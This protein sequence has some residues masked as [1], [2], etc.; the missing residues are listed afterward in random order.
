MVFLAFP[1]RILYT[2]GNVRNRAQRDGS[3][4]SAGNVGGE[5]MEAYAGRPENMEGR[6]PREI[7]T[8]DLLDRLGIEY[9]RVDHEA[10]K[11]MEACAKI[12]FCATARRRN[13]IC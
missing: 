8:Y 13:S 5:K 9:L 11:T 12:S 1:E 6:L 2:G 4:K 7:R 3:S 10:A